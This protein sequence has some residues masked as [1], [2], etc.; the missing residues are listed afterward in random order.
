MTQL[1]GRSIIGFGEGAAGKEQ[2]FGVN[3]AT[4]QALPPVF[5]SATTDDLQRAAQ[6]A[7]RSFR[8]VDQLAVA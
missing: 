5:S 2:F 6:L 7:S 1:T 3:P 4:V 8:I